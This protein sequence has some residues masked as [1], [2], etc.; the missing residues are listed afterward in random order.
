MERALADFGAGYG[1]ILPICC[2]TAGEPDIAVGSARDVYGWLAAV[3]TLYSVK[4]GSW[5]L[6]DFVRAD[7]DE[8]QIAVPNRSRFH[9]WDPDV[10]TLYR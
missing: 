1:T 6:R 7:L 9:G 2:R 4:T 3:G 8:P 5:S 10:G